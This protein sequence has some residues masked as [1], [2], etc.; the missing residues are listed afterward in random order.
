MPILDDA[1][2]Q[3]LADLVTDLAHK[4]DCLIEHTTTV[5]DPYGTSTAGTVTSRTVKC[6]VA[7]LPRPVLLQN[8][9]EQI[10]AFSK[11][12][13]GFPLNTNPQEGDRLTIPPVGGQKMIVQEV[14]SPHT[15]SVEDTV[16]AARVVTQ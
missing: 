13:V 2:L 3:D 1:D 12:T 15:F 16:I 4:D 9:N 10:G 5:D 11:W 14:Q 6:R 7:V 8:Y